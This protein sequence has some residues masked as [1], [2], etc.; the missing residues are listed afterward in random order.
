MHLRINIFVVSLALIVA[1]GAM[2]YDYG[3]K[4][5]AMQNIENRPTSTP[6]A[7]SNTGPIERHY[8]K[9]SVASINRDADTRRETGSRAICDSAP[10][11]SRG[12]SSAYKPSYYAT[13]D[14]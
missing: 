12:R 4:A 5:T 3:T 11:G 9:A 10:T 7:V 14:E 1:S 6:A 8:D 2:A 13:H